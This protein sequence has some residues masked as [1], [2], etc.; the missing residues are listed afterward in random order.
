MMKKY[1]LGALVASIPVTLLWVG[2]SPEQSPAPSSVQGSAASPA[3]DHSTMDHGVMPQDMTSTDDAAEGIKPYPLTT[4]LVSGETLG[5]MGEPV[6]VVYQGR[7]IK[8]CCKDCI[9]DFHATPDTYLK[10]LAL[11]TSTPMTMPE[12]DNS[13]AGHEHAH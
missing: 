13:H 3:R 7:E 12:S 4:C 1:L 5:G 2:C 8:L 11:A 10:K 6:R 9:Q